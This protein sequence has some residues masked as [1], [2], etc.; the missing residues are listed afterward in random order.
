MRFFKHTGL[1]AAWNMR[2]A[3]ACF[4]FAIAWFYSISVVQ[5]AIADRGK[6]PV[7][8]SFSCFAK[9]RKQKKAR[10]SRCPSGAPIMQGK[11]GNEAKLATLRQLNSCHFLPSTIGSATWKKTKVNTSVGATSVTCAGNIT[12]LRTTTI[13]LLFDLGFELGFEIGF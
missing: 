13:Y 10:K 7:A 12:A 6:R 9:K 5:C 1:R 2:N 4:W 8:T 3:A 11:M